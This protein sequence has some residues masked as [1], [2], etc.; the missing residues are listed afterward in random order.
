MSLTYADLL[1]RGEKPPRVPIGARVT[2]GTTKDKMYRGLTGT[3]VEY[4][5]PASIYDHLVYIDEW[6]EK[7]W[8]R[9]SEFT[10]VEAPDVHSEC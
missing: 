3:V 5:H 1:K 4:G 6:E 8:F 10:S 9:P 2:I 7:R